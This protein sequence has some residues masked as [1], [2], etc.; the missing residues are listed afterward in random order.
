MYGIVKY[1]ALLDEWLPLPLIFATEA[2]AA[3]AAAKLGAGHR[4][5]RQGA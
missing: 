4:A 3:A 5:Y 1:I 2:A